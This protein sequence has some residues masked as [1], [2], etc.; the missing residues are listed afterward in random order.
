MTHPEPP[1]FHPLTG[2]HEPSAIQQLPDGR[3]LVVE[4]EKSHPLSLLTIS[5]AGRV[6]SHALMPR[7]RLSRYAHRPTKRS[8]ARKW[9]Q[10]MVAPCGVPSSAAMPA[11]VV[12][13]S[14]GK[15]LGRLGRMSTV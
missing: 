5:A 3:F 11:S 10:P 14:S 2:L 12:F 15:T 4:D 9:T 6:A 7:A 13:R 1:A 8:N